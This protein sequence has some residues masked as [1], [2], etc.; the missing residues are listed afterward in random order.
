MIRV[1]SDVTIRIGND[2]ALLRAATKGFGLS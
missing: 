2:K 1:N